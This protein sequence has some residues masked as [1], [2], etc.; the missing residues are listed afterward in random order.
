MKIN[1]IGGK[2]METSCGPQKGHEWGHIQDRLHTDVITPKP[3][4]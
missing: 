4:L 2:W 3:N 1:V